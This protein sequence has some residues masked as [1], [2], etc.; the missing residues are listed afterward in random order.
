MHSIACCPFFVI[1]LVFRYVRGSFQG[2]YQSRVP[3][4]SPRH[5]GRSIPLSS[6][7]HVPG[8]SAAP[9][10]PIFAQ[11]PCPGRQV[12]YKNPHIRPCLRRRT[13]SSMQQRCTCHGAIAAFGDKKRDAPL[14]DGL[15]K[16]FLLGTCK[17]VFA[18]LPFEA[19][20]QLPQLPIIRVLQNL[21]GKRHRICGRQE[22]QRFSPLVSAVFNE[23]DAFPEP[24]AAVIPAVVQLRIARAAHLCP[25]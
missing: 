24:E 3:D 17:H 15:L 7:S 2:Q 12:R 5:T 14:F 25:A 8:T 11:C 22:H 21:H 10:L 20:F 13:S 4:T 16:P 9:L 1:I 23:T 18:D 6:R 19:I